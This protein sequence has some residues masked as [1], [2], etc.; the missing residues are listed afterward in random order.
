MG[1][2]RGAPQRPGSA[3]A[4][5]DTIPTSTP[6]QSAPTRRSRGWYRSWRARLWRSPLRGSARESQSATGT[7][8]SGLLTSR[9]RGANSHRERSYYVDRFVGLIHS[10]LSGVVFH[11]YPSSARSNPAPIAAGDGDPFG[12]PLGD[13]SP[14]APSIRNGGINE[15]RGADEDGGALGPR[16]D[17]STGASRP[18]LPP[19]L[20]G[21]EYTAPPSPRSLRRPQPPVAR[22]RASSSSASFSAA[23][24]ALAVSNFSVAFIA[25]ENVN[26]SGGRHVPPRA[27]TL[28]RSRRRVAN[29]LGGRRRGPFRI[30]SCS[31]RAAIGSLAGGDDPG[32]NPG[33][34]PMRRSRAST[35][36]STSLGVVREEGAGPPVG[37]AGPPACF[38]RG[39]RRE[40]R[41]CSPPGLIDGLIAGADVPAGSHV[42][43]CDSV[44]RRSSEERDGVPLALDFF[45]R[46]A[47][48]RGEGSRRRGEGSSRSGRGAMSQRWSSS[49]RRCRAS[50]S[51]RGII[52][53]DPASFHLGGE[54]SSLSPLRSAKMSLPGSDR[55]REAGEREC[56]PAEDGLG[57]GLPNESSPELSGDVA[58]QLARCP[59]SV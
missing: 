43:R 37:R 33:T 40:P 50:A 26:L 31:H 42:E 6:G 28:V 52:A 44:V 25:Q 59:S 27:A 16:S 36:G 13:P 21:G 2:W 54:G 45:P 4:C 46:L 19:R 22:A 35:T 20:T 8:Q 48:C 12:D 18:F 55:G 58:V 34:K 24:L 29:A 1:R 7:D 10:L 32:L 17:P 15:D 23:S 5:R 57:L 9:S 11:P 38:H 30:G 39:F 14:P 56:H 3:G 41:G 53:R 51:R 47:R 49:S